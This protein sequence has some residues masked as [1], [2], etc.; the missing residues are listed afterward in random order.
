MLF[1]LLPHHAETDLLSHDE[2]PQHAFLCLQSL[3]DRDIS[4]PFLNFGSQI[5]NALM[6]LRLIQQELDAADNDFHTEPENDSPDRNTRQFAYL[7]NNTYTIPHPQTDVTTH[8]EL[9]CRLPAH[10]V[11]Q[12][13]NSLTPSQ[14][15]GFITGEQHFTTKDNSVLHLCI[16]GSGGSGKSY[17]INLIITYLQ[18]SHYLVLGT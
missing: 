17:L 3:L 1:L 13:R 14:S 8:E 18:H 12:Q 16:S 9:C 10:L 5:D 15:R 11:A 2:S 7:H 4:N 6:R